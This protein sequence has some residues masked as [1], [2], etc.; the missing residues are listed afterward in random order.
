MD[1]PFLSRLATDYL[2]QK[3]IHLSL[4]LVLFYESISFLNNIFEQIIEHPGRYDKILNRSSTSSVCSFAN[5]TRMTVSCSFPPPR[6]QPFLAPFHPSALQIVHDEQAGSDRPGHGVA[7][8]GAGDGGV[9]GDENQQPNQAQGAYT[10]EGH[11]GGGHGFAGAAHS[12]GEDFHAGI[13]DV[14]GRDEAQDLHALFEEQD[15]RHRTF[16]RNRN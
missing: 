8:H 5:K 4:F 16:N 6:N 7:E 3:T 15:S 14:I 1:V 11:E 2:S 10:E 12:A 9:A 13:G